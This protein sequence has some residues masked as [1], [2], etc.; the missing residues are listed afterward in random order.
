MNRG[1]EKRQLILVNRVMAEQTK[2]SFPV[3]DGNV[4]QQWRAKCE[5]YFMLEEENRS[6]DEVSRGKRRIIVAEK[7]KTW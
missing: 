6:A 5:Q 4:C 1:K 2:I 7:S 3:Y